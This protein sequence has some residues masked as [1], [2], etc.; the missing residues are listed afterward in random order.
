MEKVEPSNYEYQKLYGQGESAAD[1]VVGMAPRCGRILE[2]G[3]G[4]GSITRRLTQEKGCRVTAVEVDR[5]FLS[6]LSGCCERVVQANLNSDE[7]PGA[8]GEGERFEVI[9]AADVLE[10]L[11]QPDLALAACQRLL[12]KEGSIIVSLPNIGHCAIHA[13]LMDEDFEYRKWGLLDAT[14]IRFFGLK[15]MQDLISG[16]GLK[17]VEVKF[18]SRMPED[19]EFADRWRRASDGL[20]AAVLS[21]PFAYVYQCVVRAVPVAT[22]GEA[23]NIMGCAIPRPKVTGLMTINRFLKRYLPDELYGVCKRLYGTTSRK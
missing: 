15:N 16:A 19:T 3:A 12:T 23:L 11:A 22:P 4:P 17:V 1:H 7:W 18:V 14:H 9:V 21:N 5:S 2:L 10:H 13:C 20:K 6:H 8:V